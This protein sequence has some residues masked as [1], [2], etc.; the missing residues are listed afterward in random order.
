MWHLVTITY[1]QPG[2]KSGPITCIVEATDQVNAMVQALTELRW[3]YRYPV[4]VDCKCVETLAQK[5]AFHEKSRA[6]GGA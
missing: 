3:S 4:T 2:V 5:V 6:K 1:P